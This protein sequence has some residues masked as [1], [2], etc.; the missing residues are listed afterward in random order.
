MSSTNYTTDMNKDK[1]D[2]NLYS[3]QLYA[4]GHDAMEQMRKTSVLI[5]G[6]SGLG[7]EVSKNAILSGFKSV[8][9]HDLKKVSMNDLSSQYYLSESDIGKNRVE[10]CV[11]KLAEL[12][13]YVQV[14]IFD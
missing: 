13:P 12:N 1:I 7:V 6:L 8:T 4:I 5:C 2:E 9:L 3:R 10:C 11:E 14:T